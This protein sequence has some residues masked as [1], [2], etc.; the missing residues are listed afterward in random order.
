MLHFLYINEKNIKTGIKDPWLLGN[1]IR[2][3]ECSNYKLERHENSLDFC[4][5]LENT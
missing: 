5:I 4:T 1:K 3:A 2:T